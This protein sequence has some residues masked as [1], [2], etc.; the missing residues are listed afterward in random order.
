MK[1]DAADNKVTTG[2]R[3]LKTKRGRGKFVIRNGLK[4]N[5]ILENSSEVKCLSPLNTWTCL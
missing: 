3:W 4:I 2:G 1:K 5:K